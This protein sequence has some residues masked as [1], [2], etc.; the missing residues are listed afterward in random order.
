MSNLAMARFA[1]TFAKAVFGRTRS[2]ALA[3]QTC[4]MCGKAA[5]EFRDEESRR[6]YAISG[7]CQECQDTL[8]SERLG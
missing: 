7:I 4:V 3:S 5:S 2:E 8:F 1:D 6:E